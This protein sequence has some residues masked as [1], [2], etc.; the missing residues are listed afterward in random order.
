MNLAIAMASIAIKMG[1]ANRGRH[2]VFRLQARRF[3]DGA[4]FLDDF[5]REGM[6]ASVKK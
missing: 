1:T 5:D 3:E 4:C 6:D 2:L